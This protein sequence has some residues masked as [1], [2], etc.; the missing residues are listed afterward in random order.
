MTLHADES[1]QGAAFI[2]RRS[3]ANPDE[4]LIEII[5][6][7]EGD[8]GDK[9]AKD[10]LFEKF[11]RELDKREDTFQRAVDWYFF[12]NVVNRYVNLGKRKTHERKPLDPDEIRRQV[13]QRVA[14]I[15]LM[16]M[17]LP[18]G[19]YVKDAT[20]GECAKES[21]ILAKI[22]SLGPPEEI[23]GLKLT[24]KQLQKIVGRHGI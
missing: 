20:F 9:S 18:S 21:G 22:G 24:E 6:T 2:H 19:K 1:K 13:R 3:K 8:L 14:E 17:L 7:W 10:A 11:R 23:V 16:M 12:I 4:L 5:E 15:G